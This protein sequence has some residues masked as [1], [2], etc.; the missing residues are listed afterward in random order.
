MEM[1]NTKTNSGKNLPGIGQLCDAAERFGVLLVYG[2]LAPGRV[3]IPYRSYM[4]EV[5]VDELN[6]SV[7]SRNG[8]MR[9]ELF[10]FAQLNERLMSEDDIQNIRN[11]G[12]KSRAEIIGTFFTDC[13]SRLSAEDKAE[14]WRR[15]LEE[16][17]Q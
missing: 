7:R 6:L 14:Y 15:V 9:A 1:D 12:A 8:L 11:L 16:D 2:M 5:S 10:S 13:Y 4:A 17:L 3:R